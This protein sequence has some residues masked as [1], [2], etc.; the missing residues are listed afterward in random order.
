MGTFTKW[1]NELTKALYF[2]VFRVFRGLQLPN[3]G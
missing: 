1:V 3:L 2:R